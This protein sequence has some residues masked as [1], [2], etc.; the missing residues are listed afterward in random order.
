MAAKRIRS[1][2]TVYAAISLADGWS[3]DPA[4]IRDQTDKNQAVTLKS[5]NLNNYI[6]VYSN[7][8]ISVVIL[9][10]CALRYGIINSWKRTQN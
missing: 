10:F 3:E 2:R 6:K 4:E 8:E 9:F 5:M 1:Q 7:V